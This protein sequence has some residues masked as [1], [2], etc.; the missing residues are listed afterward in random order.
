MYN[1]LSIGKASMLMM[2]CFSCKLLDG[3]GRVGSISGQI[4]AFNVGLFSRE[5]S[6]M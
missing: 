5:L 1:T 2:P 4:S 3:G 6:N